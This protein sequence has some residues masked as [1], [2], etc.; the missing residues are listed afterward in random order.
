MYRS[1]TLSR[2]SKRP[3]ENNRVFVPSENKDKRRRALPRNIALLDDKTRS[4]RTG[5]GK[6]RAEHRVANNS[7]LRKTQY[8][9][10]PLA[11]IKNT[12]S[13]EAMTPPSSNTGTLCQ[14]M[15]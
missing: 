14:K 13:L 10:S 4:K 3:L 9:P 8:L 11:S 12:V 6:L 5:S 7:D 15:N 2:T 1:K